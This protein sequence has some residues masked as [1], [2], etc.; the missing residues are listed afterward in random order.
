MKARGLTRETILDLGTEIKKHPAFKV[1]DTIIVD[2]TIKEGDKERVQPFEGDVIAKHGNGVSSTFTVRRISANGIGVEKIIPLYS[3]TISQIK[4]VKSGKARRA[5]LYYL[6]DRVG[7]AA[8]IKEKIL[9]KE[10]KIAQT[11]ARKLVQR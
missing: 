3:P 7:K 4:L 6:R 1:G 10:E 2:L 5:K 8:Q 9:T 11:A